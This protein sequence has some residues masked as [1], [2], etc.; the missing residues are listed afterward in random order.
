MGTKI[1]G[2]FRNG[3]QA[4]TPTLAPKKVAIEDIPDAEWPKVREDAISQRFNEFFESKPEHHL[5]QPLVFQLQDEKG[6]VAT[7]VHNGFKKRDYVA[8][9][10]VKAA[11]GTRR[12]AP[13]LVGMSP[14][15]NSNE[16]IQ[17]L[18]RSA[19]KLASIFV[20]TAADNEAK[21]RGALRAQMREDL[22]QTRAALRSKKTFVVRTIED[23]EGTVTPLAVDPPVD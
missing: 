1:P 19:F 9:E 22:D 23:G 11:I 14:L 5:S 7:H 17:D 12:S 20:N 4:P 6:H 10:F 15:P 13:G 8:L 18:F 16:E 21:E 2:R 3:Q